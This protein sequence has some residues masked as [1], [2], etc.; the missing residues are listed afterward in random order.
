MPKRSNHKPQLKTYQI[1]LHNQ[2]TSSKED[3]DMSNQFVLLVSNISVIFR[4]N[5]NIGLSM[6]NFQF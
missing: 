5:L 2:I 1:N 3:D 6:S 4:K